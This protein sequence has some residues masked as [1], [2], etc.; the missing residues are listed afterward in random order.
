MLNRAI[1]NLGLDPFFCFFYELNQGGHFVFRFLIETSI[2]LG[3]SEYTLKIGLHRNVRLPADNDAWARGVSLLTLTVREGN[4]PSQLRASYFQI[5]I[6][7][8]LREPLYGF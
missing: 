8:R 2:P 4:L 5:V 1:D 6:H 3:R 7:L